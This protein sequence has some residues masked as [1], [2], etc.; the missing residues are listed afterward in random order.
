VKTEIID[1]SRAT[2]AQLPEVAALLSSVFKRKKAW[3]EEL[4]W[5]Y[6]EHPRGPSWWVNVRTDGGA[7]VAH[8]ALLAVSP[9]DGPDF[10][11]IPVWF[12]LNT[13]VR[14]DA[15]QPGLMIAGIRT[16]L[17]KV[18]A[19]GPAVLLGVANANS[20]AG[21]TRLLKF[22]SLGPLSLTLLPPWQPPRV[23]VPRAVRLEAQTLKWRAGR[24]GTDTYCGARGGLVMRRIA[25]LGLPLDG[26]LTADAP[27]PVLAEAAL[28]SRPRSSWLPAPR[29]YASFAAP[30]GGGLPIPD[31]LKPSPLHY[32]FRSLAK[33]VDQAALAGF[34]AGRR[35]EFIDF[36][37]L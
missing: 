10:D 30:V 9:L 24:P 28:A 27:A 15:T 22:A 14:P 1:P 6:L 8:S 36:D 18:E 29:L 25:H 34:L 32:I 33:G 3:L 12:S 13:A 5:E 4:R 16:L 37:V 2:A 19:A 11:G 31:R 23:S 20:A 26:V 17:Q 35:F 21:F 7:L